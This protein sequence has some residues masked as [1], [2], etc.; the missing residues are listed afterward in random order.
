VYL[1]ED[2]IP[3]PIS[4]EIRGSVSPY[5]KQQLTKLLEE[6]LGIAKENQLWIG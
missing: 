6:E 4:V 1:S 5:G 3:V 2:T